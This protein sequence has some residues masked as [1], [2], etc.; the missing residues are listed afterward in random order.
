MNDSIINGFQAEMEKIGIAGAGIART[1]FKKTFGQKAKSA[2]K[3]YKP[4]KTDVAITAGAAG[5]GALIGNRAINKTN[6]KREAFKKKLT[7]TY[8]PGAGM[9]APPRAY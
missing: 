3:K 8:Q 4:T 6:R 1:A 2:Y 5:A 9:I 7:G